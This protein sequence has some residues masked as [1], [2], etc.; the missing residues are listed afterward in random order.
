[1][2]VMNRPGLLRPGRHG[3][4]I[5]RWL[6]CGLAAALVLGSTSA[7]QARRW[8]PTDQERAEEYLQILHRKSANELVLLI[9]LAPSILGG[10]PENETGMEVLS[11]Y[12][13]IM[14]AHAETTALGKQK[15]KIPDGVMIETGS[16]EFRRRI[17]DEDLP[18]VVSITKSLIG[19]V[20]AGGFGPF[21]PNA[22]TFLFDGEGIDD[23]GKGVL[24][25]HYDGERYEYLTPIPGCR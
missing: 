1:M 20:F 3:P 15:F 13:I 10:A 17:P 7:G 9:W 25:V 16:G 23:C 6:A 4:A 11:R 24:W 21:G 12:I 14:L 2:R 5:T 18:P 19:S 8:K 22:D